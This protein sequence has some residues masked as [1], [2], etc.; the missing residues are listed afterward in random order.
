MERGNKVKGVEGGG[1]VCCRLFAVLPV[2]LSAVF[3]F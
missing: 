1:D 2:S 3:M